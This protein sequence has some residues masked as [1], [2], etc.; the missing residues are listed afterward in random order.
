[1]VRSQSRIVFSARP[2][3][4][5]QLLGTLRGDTVIVLD[6]FAVPGEGTETRVTALDEAYE[7]MVT[8]KE[9]LEKVRF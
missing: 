9:L 3:V 7:Y 1:M 2:A 4:M 5:G 6:T 8:Y